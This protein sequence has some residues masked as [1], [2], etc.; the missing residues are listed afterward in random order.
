[1]HPKTHSQRSQSTRQ[2]PP[3]PNASTAQCSA[4]HR[5]VCIQ[6]RHGPLKPQTVA[7]SLSL[8]SSYRHQTVNDPREEDHRLLEEM[9]DASVVSDCDESSIAGDVDVLIDSELSSELQDQPDLDDQP[10][11]E[12]ELG[13]EC[14]YPISTPAA[15]IELE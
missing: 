12:V 11:L 10:E 14:C 3:T 2:T 5:P 7:R 1:G 15:P 8:Q 13:P 6:G 9:Q 4:S